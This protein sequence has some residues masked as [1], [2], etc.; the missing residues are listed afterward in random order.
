M[1]L[2]LVFFTTTVIC[3][4]AYSLP[5]TLY[6]SSASS[7]EE[8]QVLVSSALGQRPLSLPGVGIYNQPIL[9]AVK[10]KVPRYLTPDI[11]KLYIAQYLAA[12]G[13]T[14]QDFA[15]QPAEGGLSNVAP[16]DGNVAP[17]PEVDVVV[18]IQRQVGEV[19][20][21][22]VPQVDANRETVAVAVPVAEH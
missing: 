20:E 19:S 10:V 16:A 5:Y 7:E 13:L 6:G 15:A 18:R 4:Y 21:V 9:Q 14:L 8:Y 17:T 3:A 12:R 22:A 1:K 11:K 2:P